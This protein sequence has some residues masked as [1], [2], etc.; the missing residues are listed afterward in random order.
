MQYKEIAT[1]K[2]YGATHLFL[3]KDL[4][5]KCFCVL[6]KLVLTE[7]SFRK[8]LFNNEIKM[9]KKFKCKNIVKFLGEGDDPL[10][11]F[12]EYSFSGSLKKHIEEKKE[13]NIL[14]LTNQIINALHYIHSLGIVHNDLN[15]SNILIFPDNVF[16]LID[17]ELAGKIGEK[18]FPDKPFGFLIGTQNFVKN[19]KIIYNKIENDIF[20]LG[21]LLYKTLKGKCDKIENINFKNLPAPFDR[22]IYKC[23]HL[24]YQNVLEIQKD[25]KKD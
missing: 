15:D 22:I 10:S 14:N 3:V 25:L 12:M 21:M 5:Q 6:K 18:A 13:I 11:F 2:K 7:D 24:E 19:N 4:E 8:K 1:I 20:S 9:L 23:L 17:F 16:K